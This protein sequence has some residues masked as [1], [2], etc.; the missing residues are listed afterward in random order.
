[1]QVQRVLQLSLL[2]FVIFSDI[3][4]AC[5]FPGWFPDSSGESAAVEDVDE[6]VC[7]KCVIDVRVG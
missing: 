2:L 3:C 7:R 4:M 1:M 6:G 5:L